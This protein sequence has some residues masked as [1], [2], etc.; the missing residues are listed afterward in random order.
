MIIYRIKKYNNR[1]DRN[2]VLPVYSV[3]DH[4]VSWVLRP[5]H[6]RKGRMFF[7]TPPTDGTL[8]PISHSPV[9][10]VQPWCIIEFGANAARGW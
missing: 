10:I 1:I 4:F 7:S 3:V 6:I 8:Y 2:A 5:A 9:A